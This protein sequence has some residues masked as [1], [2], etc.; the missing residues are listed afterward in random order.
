MESSEV[1]KIPVP[2]KLTASSL[3]VKPETRKRVLAELAKV[4]KKTFGRK[5]RVDQVLNLLLTLLKPEHIK[6]LQEESLSNA[7]RIEINYREHIKRH[8]PIS[9]DEF[10]GLLLSAEGAKSGSEKV[11]FSERKN[12]E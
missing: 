9:K 2:K 11:T 1:K 4:N 12:D 3:R 6:T 8:G 7:D 10:L 5:V